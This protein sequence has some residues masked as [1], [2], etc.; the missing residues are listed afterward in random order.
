MFHSKRE[1][2]LNPKPRHLKPFEYFDQV[3]RTEGARGWCKD[4]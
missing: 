2:E 1:L 4:R 3:E